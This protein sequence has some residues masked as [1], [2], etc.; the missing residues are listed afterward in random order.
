MTCIF[1][2]VTNGDDI[3]VFIEQ[4]AL[5]KVDSFKYLGS[6]ISH[7]G[8]IDEDVYHRT[9]TGWLKW[10]Q[11]TGVMC[12]SRIPLKVKGKSIKQQL[13]QLCCMAQ[14]VGPLANNT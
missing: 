13:G 11:L 2:G 7:D 5:P 6:I 9:A 12:D 4:V 1:D 14:N 3:C 10:R 8:K